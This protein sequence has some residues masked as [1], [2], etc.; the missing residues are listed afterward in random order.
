MAKT[1]RLIKENLNLIDIVF[2]LIDAR[3]PYSSRIKDIDD[4]IKNK[5]RVII[6]TKYDLCD[7]EETNKWVNYYESLN[8]KVLKYNLLE[9]SINDIYDV[10]DELLEPLNQKL[11]SK[12]L[13]KENI[14]H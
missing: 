2:E 9:G 14:E 4:L 11:E 10:I 6:I 13:L 5:P 7:K 8:Y 1:K 3:I 12:D